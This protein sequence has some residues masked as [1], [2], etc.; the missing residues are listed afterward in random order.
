ML[1]APGEAASIAG[2]ASEPWP[3]FQIIMWQNQTPARL[4]GLARLGITAASI[5][6]RR[7]PIEADDVAG[8]IAPLRSL[9]LRWY[10]ENI[11][12]VRR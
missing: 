2:S 3:D 8:S 7:G 11:D 6:G 9:G 10:V 4:A 1:G 5:H 12:S